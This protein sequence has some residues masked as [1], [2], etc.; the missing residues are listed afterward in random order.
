MVRTVRTVTPLTWCVLLMA[1]AVRI[2][3]RRHAVSPLALRGKYLHVA[4]IAVIAGSS[5][6]RAGSAPPGWALAIV[7]LFSVAALVGIAIAVTAWRARRGTLTRQATVRGLVLLGA[8][9]AVGLAGYI[10]VSVS[11]RTTDGFPPVWV[12]VVLQVVSFLCVVAAVLV[13]RRRF[14]R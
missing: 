10:G 4:A 7:Y 12:A 14:S 8:L 3:S 13:T 6:H 11:K 1:R 2:D 9:M 5:Q